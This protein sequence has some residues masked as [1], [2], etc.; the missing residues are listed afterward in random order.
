MVGSDSES[1]RDSVE[2]VKIPVK[3]HDYEF[4]LWQMEEL[5]LSASLFMLDE[6]HR[7][8]TEISGQRLWAGSHLLSHYLAI[9]PDLING[10]RV[11]ELGAGT[12]CCSMV[13]SRLSPSCIVSTDGDA[14][15]VQ[16]L[17]QNIRYN[18]CEKTSAHEL[19][20]GNTESNKSFETVMD[21]NSFNVV[22]AGDVLY[23]KELLIPFFQTVKKYLNG[24]LLLCHI[25]RADV[26]HKL[27]QETATIA[28]GFKLEF[29][30][31]ADAGDDDLASIRELCPVED[32]KRAKIYKIIV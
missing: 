28:F 21:K 5:S 25:P 31:D 18:K 23:K 15:V 1:W 7:E 10:K 12:G 30:I 8:G 3:I 14:E 13:S 24:V 4:S 26:T 11:L 22:I 32:I 20:W 16:L 19:L 6:M 2:H 9:N 27:V 29:V 17:Q